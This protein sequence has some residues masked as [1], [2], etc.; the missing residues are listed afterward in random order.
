MLIKIYDTQHTL[1]LNLDL[2]CTM[3]NESPNFAIFEIKAFVASWLGKPVIANLAHIWAE[4]TNCLVINY[5]P[6]HTYKKVSKNTK[7][8]GLSYVISPG[9]CEKALTYFRHFLLFIV[10]KKSAKKSRRNKT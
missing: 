2:K 9:C 4:D 1:C 10:A 5:F 7:C 3:I 8:A 6:T